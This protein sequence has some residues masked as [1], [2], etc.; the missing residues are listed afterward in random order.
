M[1]NNISILLG[2]GFS[3]NKG[4]PVGN[5]LNKLLLNCDLNL[6]GFHTGGGLMVSTDGKK[7]SVGYKTSYDINAEFCIEMFKLFNS[8]A[9]YFDYEEFYDFLKDKAEED[10]D[11]QTLASKY[12]GSH[13][14]KVNDLLFGCDNILNQLISYYIKDGDGKRYY[15]DEPF[16][17]SDTFPG[18]T[19][20]MN[21]IREYSKENIVHIHSLNHDLFFESFT[22]TQFLPDLSDGFEEL[23][24]PYYGDLTVEGR[25]YRCRIPHYTGKYDSNVRL[26]KLHGSFDYGVYHSTE[27]A[28]MS[29]ENYLKTRWGIGFSNFYREKNNNG[30]LEYER[31]WVNYHADFL[32]GTTSK[33]QRYKE[34]LLY[35]KL[36]EIFQ[37]NLKCSR[38][39]ILIGYG[40]RDTEINKILLSYYNFKE[41]PSFVIDLYPGTAVK[42]LCQSI[43]AKLIIKDLEDITENDLT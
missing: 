21:V 16:Y 43:G 23:G 28:V 38:K 30:L 22:N 1:I 3:A 26:Y 17:I 24:S 32:T 9:G 27:R 11:V 39:L 20:I 15:D 6:I 35:K 10:G 18:Y 37:I 40:A 42:N 12:F 13:F 29:A 4:Y 14:S 5:T 7:P 31:D 8:K 41:K 36:F 33:I 25:M 2:A 19:G 34:P